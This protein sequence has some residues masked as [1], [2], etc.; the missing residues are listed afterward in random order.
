MTKTFKRC[1]HEKT[2]ENVSG[3]QCRTC[4]KMQQR[5]QKM[6]RRTA[7]EGDRED[8]TVLGRS[9]ILDHEGLTREDRFAQRN[10]IL[11][12][13]ALAHALQQALAA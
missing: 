9:F 1:G 3:K 11:G 6:Q 5:I 4:K 2:P 12:S 10:M 7:P 13:R 8:C